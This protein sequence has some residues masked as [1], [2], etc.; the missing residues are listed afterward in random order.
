ML[1]IKNAR[2][3]TMAGKI[4]ENGS[5]LIEGSK[6]KEVGADLKAPLQ[7][8]QIDAAGKNIYPGFIDAHSQLGINESGLG[9]EGRDGHE[10]VLPVAPH[11][12]AFDAINPLDRMFQVA[13]S[14]GLTT[15][16]IGPTSGR[17]TVIAGSMSAIKTT[18]DCIDDMILA[19]CVGI[20]CTMGPT[21]KHLALVAPRIP[22]SRTTI[23]ALMRDTFLKT[24]QYKAVKEDRPQPYNMVYEAMIPVMEKKM[25]IVVHANLKE[26]VFNAIRVAKE[27]DVRLILLFVAEA[28]LIAK[29]LK[30]EQVPCLLGPLHAAHSNPEVRHHSKTAAA[31][32][33]KA[34]ASFAII[35]N[36]GRSKSDAITV[37][38]ALAQAAGLAEIEALKA[39]TIYPA[40]IYGIDKRV[41]SLEAGK[42]ADLVICRGNPLTRDGV[43]EKVFVNGEI[44]YSN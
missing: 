34:G 2:I 37:Q 29:D 28:H 19:E 24:L 6:I 33:S 14:S 31:E 36:T 4:I 21:A 20:R 22:S 16:I 12:R 7:A 42:D 5:L 23:A 18:G 15:A 10:G 13:N 26:D 40:Q 39:I 1:F 32:L 11:L 9:A 8:E 17:G 41:G 3:Y 30:K 44:T 25:P 27:Y 38:A 43:I 35:G